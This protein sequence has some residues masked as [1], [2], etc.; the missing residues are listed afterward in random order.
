MSN[1]NELSIVVAGSSN[2]NGLQRVLPEND[3][4]INI[5]VKGANL[6][7]KPDMVHH[8]IQC[9]IPMGDCHLYLWFGNEVD[10]EARILSADPILVNN[11]SLVNKLYDGYLDGNKKKYKHKDPLEIIRLFSGPLLEECELVF[12]N[13]LNAIKILLTNIPKRTTIKKLS[14]ILMGPRY[15]VNLYETLLLNL[16]IYFVNHKIKVAIEMKCLNHKL[17]VEYISHIDYFTT[18]LVSGIKDILTR[19]LFFPPEK[20]LKKKYGAVHYVDSVYETLIQMIKR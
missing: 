14:I 12:Q 2:V 10:T 16:M 15:K 6:F 11:E 8:S 3:K 7:T 13:Y 20:N 9:N 5:G 1:F 19:E 18:F 17:N 4:I